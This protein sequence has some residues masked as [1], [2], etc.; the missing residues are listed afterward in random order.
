MSPTEQGAQR[1]TLAAALASPSVREALVLWT[2]SFA[3]I[4]AASLLMPG[5]AKVVATISFLYLPLFFARSSRLRGGTKNSWWE[6]FWSF[7]YAEFGVTLRNWRVDLKLALLLFLIVAPLYLAAYIGYAEAIKWLPARWAIHLSPYGGHWGFHPRLPGHFGLWAI[8]QMLVV[9]VPEEFF[10]RGYLQTRFREAWPQ[11]RTFVGARL[12][13]AFFV[14]AVLFA[15]GHLA[16][17]QFWRLAVFFPALL[18]GWLRERT[19]TVLGSSV[20]HALFNLYEMVLRASFY[21]V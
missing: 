9:A 14:T 2:V 7:D 5:Y 3:S 10:Y 18:F 13:P 12:G 16:I 4:V 11:G 17:F 6:R 19:G 1:S 15:V 8:D 21:P 20:L